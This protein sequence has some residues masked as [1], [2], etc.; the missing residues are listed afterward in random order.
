MKVRF[1]ALVPALALSLCAC[2]PTGGLSP[3]AQTDIANAL[4]AGC[5]ILAAVSGNVAN[6]SRSQAAYWLLASVCPPN[7]APTNAAVAALDI[8]NAYYL[9]KA[10]AK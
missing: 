10:A 8:L 4:A 3:A 6:D 9:L 5:P 7:P 2:T 1:L